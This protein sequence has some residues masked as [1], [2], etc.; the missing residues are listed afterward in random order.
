MLDYNTIIIILIISLI[1]ISII[2][3][4]IKSSNYQYLLESPNNY[5]FN[6]KYLDSVEYD[7]NPLI[8]C[9]DDF[10]QSN[11]I[12]KK[13]A[14][15]SLSGGVDS[16]VLLA[17]LLYL[18]KTHKF[19]IFSATIDYGLRKESNDESNF[20]NKYTK[21]FG[22]KSYIS[23][24]KG[25][26]RKNEASRCE[27]EE[28]SR[29]L[30]FKT[31]KQIYDENKL[32]PDL[33]VFVAHHQDDIVE[34]I[35]TNSMRGANLIDL[36]VMKP[37][38]KINGIILYRPFLGFKKKVIYEFAHKFGVPN[39]RDTTPK[40]SKRGKMRNE[41]FPLLN[42][43]FGITWQNKLKQLG[44]QSN[45]WNDYIYNYVLKP[46]LTEVQLGTSG[47]IIPIKDQPQLIYYHIIM[48]SLHAIKENML[49][50][51]SIN[52][53]MEC[54]KNKSSKLIT[55]DNFRYGIL[56]ENN[57]Y[58]IIFNSKNIKLN[59]YD[60]GDVFDGLI[61]GVFNTTKC[62]SLTKLIQKLF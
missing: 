38:S 56:I 33:G 22:I 57:E 45:E 49:K 7:S 30:R 52:K 61:N 39:F 36:E 12:Y 9:L 53:I 8:K 44:T 17:I 48:K 50:Q 40:W 4:L 16:M 51:T 21:M 32:D 3:K 10:C 1:F 28:E 20:L 24:I 2:I 42:S 62:P 54:I 6:P 13:G 43:V 26:S 25:I 41:I 15:V 35:F 27:F 55:L 5:I 34:N 47:I 37:I 46:W 14:I 23:Y 18:Q 19:P 59:N 31:Y 58:I 11:N 60:S 29:N